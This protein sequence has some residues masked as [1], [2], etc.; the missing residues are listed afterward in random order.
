LLLF[1]KFYYC[2]CARYG[3]GFGDAGWDSDCDFNSDRVVDVVDLF[4]LGD[5]F[6]MTAA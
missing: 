5:N 4:I 1:G 2:N 3:S 6:G